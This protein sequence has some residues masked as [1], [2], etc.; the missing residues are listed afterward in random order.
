MELDNELVKFNP[1][2]CKALGLTPVEARCLNYVRLHTPL[3]A[4]MKQTFPGVYER[5]ERRGLIEMIAGEWRLTEAG[6]SKIRV[7][8]EGK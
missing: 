8:L 4:R 3:H 6:K 1:Y 2:R 5:L 7:L